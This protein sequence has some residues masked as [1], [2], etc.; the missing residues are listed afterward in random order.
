[1]GRDGFVGAAIFEKDLPFQFMKIGIGWM[2]IR[3]F[4]DFIERFFDL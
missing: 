3:Q 4:F 2:C 1:M